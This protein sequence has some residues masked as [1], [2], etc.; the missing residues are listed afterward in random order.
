[1][2]R[3]GHRV[4][5]QNNLKAPF[6]NQ[7]FIFHNMVRY[8][9]TK[10][11][12]HPLVCVP[13]TQ[14]Y[15]QLANIHVKPTDNVLEVGSAHGKTTNLLAT[16][17]KNVVGI[18]CDRKML[19]ASVATYDR[20]NM[21]FHYFNAL[22]L[23]TT[24]WKGQLLP[25]GID[26]FSVVFIDC[27]GTIP[28]YMLAP[29]L[30]AIKEGVRPRLIVCKSLNLHKLQVQL[31]EGQT[32]NGSTQM[33]QSKMGKVTSMLHAKGGALGRCQH[34]LWERV[35]HWLVKQP[36]AH[37][38]V[39][40]PTPN[41]VRS[42]TN[43]S[44]EETSKMKSW[45]ARALAANM[46]ADLMVRCFLCS[47]DGKEENKVVMLAPGDPFP[48][49]PWLK[50]NSTIVRKLLSRDDYFAY[51]KFQML[52]PFS[53][54]MPVV[55]ASSCIEYLTK[56]TNHQVFIECSPG[57]YLTFT[58]QELFAL[59]YELKTNDVARHGVEVDA[60][61]CGEESEQEIETGIAGP[62]SSLFFGLGVVA[63]LLG[64]FLFSKSKR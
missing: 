21:S 5:P 3:N 14:E 16:I 56:N 59:V 9:Q 40:R 12:F 32:Y 25:N 31:H 55:L 61:K 62:S 43:I 7:A 17:A 41:V 30:K 23:N 27:G 33:Q 54:G 44:K 39:V 35:E 8:N 28:M 45:R 20:P 47:K 19:A 2:G 51:S 1:M 60:A 34:R 58:G 37:C 26:T 29:I 15:R 63:A 64:S 50:C 46:N 6:T 48:T 10:R 24:D 42:A 22:E 53:H 38:R 36:N 11:G 18:D 4:L 57:Y 13:T 49:A 52:S